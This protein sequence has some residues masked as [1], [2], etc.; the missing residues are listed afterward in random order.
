MKIKGFANFKL[1]LIT[2]KLKLDGQGGLFL[3][4]YRL[5]ELKGFGYASPEKSTVT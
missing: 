3:V 2:L 5:L 4:V 1:L